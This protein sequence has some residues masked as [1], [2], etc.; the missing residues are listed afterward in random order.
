MFIGFFLVFCWDLPCIIFYTECL[1]IKIKSLHG[2][3]IDYT[4][5]IIFSSNWYLYW[6]CIRGQP[7]MD[8]I[9]CM[10]K[11]GT[12]T[13]HFIDVCY[14][15]DFVSVGLMPY[16]FRLR[17][18]SAHSTENSNSTIQNSERTFNF[19][20]KIYVTGSINDIDLFFVPE[21]GSNGRSYGN[22]AFFFL[23]HPVHNSISVMNLAHFVND[24]GVEQYPF[25]S[26]CLT[27][28]DMSHYT[29]ITNRR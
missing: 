17:F 5:E 26:S 27:G 23:S 18:Y 29:N 3:Q 24:A 2:N 28:I 20:C 25:G 19:R 12:C 14:S 4:I 15:R 7:V 9:H 13:I 16:C 10:I 8:H 22:T 6:Q 1:L 21:T 11:I